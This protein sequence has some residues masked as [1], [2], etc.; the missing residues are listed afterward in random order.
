MLAV[1]N[2]R[3][4][5]RERSTDSLRRKQRTNHDD[6]AQRALKLRREKRRAGR[7]DANR[8]SGARIEACLLNAQETSSAVGFP[9]DRGAEELLISEEPSKLTQSK[10]TVEFSLRVLVWIEEDPAIKTL[11]QSLAAE[12]RW[13]MEVNT[14]SNTLAKKI[15]FHAS[16]KIMHSTFTFVLACIKLSLLLDL[17]QQVKSFLFPSILS[18]SYAAASTVTSTR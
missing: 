9:I 5:S 16:A 3:N 6:V 7:K 15:P 8:A 17:A 1:Q 14:T 11:V 12:L 13:K 10:T 4:A 2:K 18:S